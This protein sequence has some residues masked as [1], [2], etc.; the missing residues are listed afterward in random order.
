ME[1]EGTV[2]ETGVD[3]LVKIVKDRGRIALADAA[4]ELGVSQAVIQEW[5]NFLEDEGIISV[6]YKLTKPYLVERKLTKKEVESKAEEFA[7]KKDVFVRKA[8]VSLNFIEKQE[9]E[10][11]K[12]KG[13]FDKLKNEL[14]MQ[15]DDVRDELGELER[16]QQLK[17]NIQNQVEEQKNDTKLKMD[18]L[19]RQITIEQKRYRDLV[20]DVRKEHD[21]LIRE[22]LEAKSIEESEKI[23]NKRLADLKAMISLIE[24]KVSDEDEAIKNSESHIER[25]SNLVEDIK[26]NV[27]EEKSKIDPLIEKSR[28]QEKKFFELQSQIIKKIAE[29]QKNAANVK[30]ITD[31]V[32][33]FFEKKLAVVNLVDRI[34]KDRDELEKNLIELIKKAKAFQLAAKGRDVSRDMTE[35]GKKFEEV[36][37]KKV[38][39]EEELK[40]LTSFFK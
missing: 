3:R 6:E 37:K 35:L 38:V 31:K 13:E 27:E 10:L 19:I 34:N 5:M 2:I 29:N 39:F 21:E 7:S 32:N 4:V 33:A 11:K 23:F 8:E 26:Y 14:G 18:E 24:K 40:K 9:W 28:E 22:K 36:D 20:T 1:L 30:E 17:Q 12:I 15:L 16:Y 25:L